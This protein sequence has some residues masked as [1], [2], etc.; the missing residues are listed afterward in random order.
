MSAMIQ[1]D[2]FKEK[3]SEIEI[4]KADL[5][6]TSDSLHKVRKGTFARMSNQEKRILELEMQVD[7]LVNALCKKASQ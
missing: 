4:L 2:L 1:F 6:A 7:I 5:Q 3:P